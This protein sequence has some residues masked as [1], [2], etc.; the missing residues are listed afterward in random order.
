MNPVHTLFLNIILLSVEG[1]SYV[2]PITGHKAYTG[3]EEEDDP[4]YI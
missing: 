3:K 1:L 4:V 2:T